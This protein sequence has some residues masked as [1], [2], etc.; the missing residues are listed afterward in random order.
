MS[1]VS[2]EVMKFRWYSEAETVPSLSQI[3][4]RR[5]LEINLYIHWSWKNLGQFDV[6][7]T[8]R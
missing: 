1:T 5:H 6:F 7:E 3:Y 4:S 8:E 2:D